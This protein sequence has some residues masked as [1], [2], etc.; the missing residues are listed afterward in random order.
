[1]TLRRYVLRRVLLTLPILLGVSM[2]T[3]GLV[4]LLPGT[5]VDYVLQFQE[6]TPELRAQLRAQYHLDDPVWK[7]YLLWL[8]DVLRLDFG[9]RV[10]S[11]RSVAAAVGA[12]LPE[13]LALGG[14]AFLVA[15]GIGV[16]A[17]VLAAVTRGSTVDELTR[18]GA[19]VG[20][21][22]PNFWLGLL[23][24]LAFGVNL[25]WFRVL[26]PIA[27]PLA[28]A[29]L[30]FMLLPAVTLGTASAALFARITRASVSEQLR[31]EYVRAARARGLDER[32]VVGKHVLR[33]ALIPVVTV[34]AVQVAVLVDGAVVVERV[35]SWPGLGRLLVRAI[36]QRDFPVVQAVVL[37]VGVV[38]VLAN[39]LADV[40]YAWLDPRIRY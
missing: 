40:A 34:A 28:P 13:T 6:A 5:P 23:L 38:V 8:G 17:G 16:P 11:G 26:P 9:E 20:I 1:M 18:V 39:L 10:V 15:V 24:I 37:L 4:K 2:L 30:K 25:G 19:L 21:A 22:T 3:F 32:T 35:F 27:P 31:E 14:F 7:Q 29:S 33:N 12:R 36:L